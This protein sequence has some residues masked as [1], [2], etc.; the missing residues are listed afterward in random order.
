MRILK[1]AM[2]PDALLNPGVMLPASDV[3]A[4]YWFGPG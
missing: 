1:S 2:D 3:K 4:K